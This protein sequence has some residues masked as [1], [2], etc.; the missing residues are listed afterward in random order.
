M[1]NEANEALYARARGRGQK[2][3]LGAIITRRSSHLL[4]LQEIAVGAL[5]RSPAG[6]QPSVDGL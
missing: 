6:P 4:S 2:A 1:V 3:L 5:L